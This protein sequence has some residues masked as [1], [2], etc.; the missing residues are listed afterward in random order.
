MAMSGRCLCGA[1]KFT[2]QNVETDHHAC[3][4]ATCRRWQGGSPFFAAH[5]ESVV[6]EED[7]ALARYES[8]PWAKRGFCRT[9][10]TT[11]F[12]YLVPGDRYMISVGAFD[13]QAPFR[14]VR[15]IFIDHKPEGYAFVGDH[16]RW[17]EAETFA[18]LSPPEP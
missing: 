4:C 13:D 7:G 2:A 1:V 12:Y 5:C 8:S 10:G 6:F 11:L 18:R 17:D 16:P 3:H 15:E 9:C 14:L